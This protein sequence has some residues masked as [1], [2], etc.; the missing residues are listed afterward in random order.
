M[1]CSPFSRYALAVLRLSRRF[2][3]ERVD[4]ACALALTGPVR[5]A[6]IETLPSLKTKNQPKCA[7]V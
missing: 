1:A 5:S 6:P 4:A 3:S 7:E 2:S